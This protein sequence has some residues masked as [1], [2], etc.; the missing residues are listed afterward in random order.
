MDE[1]PGS[2]SELGAAKGSGLLVGSSGGSDREQEAPKT[3]R[4][5]LR[6]DW[7][8]A[9]PTLTRM[10]SL[11]VAD[12]SRVYAAFLV[13]LDLLEARNWHEVSYVGLAEFQLVC[14]RGREREADDLQVVVPVPVHV[15]FSHDWFQGRSG[16]LQA[17][18]PDVNTGMRQIMKR[19]CTVSDSPMSIMLAI[20][21]SDS[22]IVYYKLT[23][24]L[25]TP[26][27]PDNT[28]DADNKQWGKKRKRLLR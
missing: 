1:A 15:S 18:Q 8:A 25:V 26:D 5:E 3:G 12:S 13:Y 24:G 28:E 4:W 21:E 2:S 6:K 22:T 19:T 16:K 10:T 17:S 11:D 27:P 7:L 14:L 20:V 9:H 23:D